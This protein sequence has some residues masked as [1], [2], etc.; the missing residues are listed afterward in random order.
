[1]FNTNSIS[2]FHQLLGCC[3]LC[4]ASTIG[5]A[6]GA[7]DSNEPTGEVTIEISYGIQPV[8]EG[9]LNLISEQPGN[10]RG[11]ELGSDGVATVSDLALGKYTVTVFPPLPDPTP[12]QSAASA[13]KDFSN[14]PTK[15][16]SAQTSPLKI[17]VTEGTK[18]FN[19]DL[20]DSE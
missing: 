18:D 8:T 10:D 14:I 9:Q 16:R 15:F 7:A 13:Q 11:G 3:L 1:M 5:C 19:F 4:V 2:R 20:K 6:G 17:E 12:D